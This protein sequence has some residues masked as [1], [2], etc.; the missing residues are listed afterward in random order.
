MYELFFHFIVKPGITF[1][2]SA[3]NRFQVRCEEEA[4]AGVR[5]EWRGSLEELASAIKDSKTLDESMPIAYHFWNSVVLNEGESTFEDSLE[6]WSNRPKAIA[7]TVF[8][9]D[10]EENRDLDATLRRFLES[11]PTF[12]KVDHADGSVYICEELRLIQIDGVVKDHL[13][14]V[15]HRWIGPIKTILDQINPIETER[16]L[17]GWYGLNLADMRDPTTSLKFEITMDRV[18]HLLLVLRSA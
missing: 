17:L 8:L 15:V 1:G 6:D 13:G 12:A 3:K 14:F 18:E 2:I 10:P 16:I 9:E 7:T 4:G 11:R 5:W